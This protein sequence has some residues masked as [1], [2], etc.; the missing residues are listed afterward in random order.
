MKRQSMW[1]ASPIAIALA[2]SANSQPAIAQLPSLET[3]EVP[4]E[5]VPEEN[6][7]APRGELPNWDGSSQEPLGETQ[8]PNQETSEVP[9]EAVPA[10][11]A[12]RGEVPSLDASSQEPLS[13]TPYTLGAGDGIQ[14]TVFNV[15][16]YS[17]TFRV[18]VDGTLNLPVVGSL[19]VAGLTIAQASDLI[20][21]QYEPILQR[22]IVTV[23]LADPRPLRIAISGEI[24]RPGSYVLSPQGGAQFPTV[25]QAIVAAGGVTRSAD[26]RA[27]VV[28]RSLSQGDRI[29]NVNLW[30]LARTGELDEDITLRDG[31]RISI[32]TETTNNQRES[33]ILARASFATVPN[34]IEVAVVGEVFRPGTYRI[35]AVRNEE[36][37]SAQAVQTTLTPPTLTQAIQAAGGITN[38]SDVRE[39]E[40]RRIT[41]DGTPQVL[42]ANLWLLLSEGDVTQNLVLDAGDTVVVPR[43]VAVDPMEAESLAAASFA[44]VAIAVSVIGEVNR[45]GTLQVP[46]NTPLSQA[47]LAAGGFNQTRARES[48]VELV[49]L[50]PDGTVT[51][52]EIAVDLSAPIDPETN[53]LLRRNDVVIVDRSTLTEISDT[54][55]TILRPIGQFF[56]FIN[57][58]DLFD[59]N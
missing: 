4:P 36:R 30:E 23:V 39:I 55:S 27:I 6:P 12:P 49:R 34:T 9:P 38:L 59:N 37:D 14:V 42:T 31:D 51:K 45:P 10:L 47:I 58:F 56:S 53:P 44:P 19:D 15:P 5:A 18:L 50:N 17:G 52:R 2:L 35:G 13:E 40:V 48:T 1:I 41:R 32:P 11:E 21:R 26:V 28:R 20:S 29:L 43:A 57:F 33:R 16:E 8:L 24:E 7:Q 22:P 54:A 46:A 3:S 25:S